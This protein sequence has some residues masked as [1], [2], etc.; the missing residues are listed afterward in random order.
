MAKRLTATI[1]KETKQLLINDFGYEPVDL[2]SY[3]GQIRALKESF[4]TLQIKNPKDPRL[5]QL[6]IAVK[7]LRADRE[8]EKD[9]TG[10]L[11]KTRKRRKDAKSLEQ[12]Q[13]EIDAKEKKP[14]AKTTK[15]TA[16]NIVPNQSKMSGAAKGIGKSPVAE[17]SQNILETIS[18]NVSK[19]V[20]TLKAM[21][22]LSVDE[23]K[24]DKLR[25]ED[26][27]REKKETSLEKSKFAVFKEVGS[28]ILKPFQG[29]FGK[30]LDFIKT[31]LLGKVLME[32][33]KWMGDKKNQKSLQNIFKFLKTFWPTLLAAYLLFGNSF[34]KMVVKITAKVAKFGV[35]IVKKLIPKLLAA[36]AKLKT[37]KFLNLIKGNKG[38]LITGLIATGV[39][40]YGISKMGGDDDEEEGG[41]EDTQEFK[42]GGFVSGPAGPDQVPARLTAGEFVMSKGAVEKYGVN[43]LAAMNAAG[44]GTNIPT[45]T[46]EY[47]DGGIV[48]RSRF[49]N[50]MGSP[51]V[52]ANNTQKVNYI[53]GGYVG[54]SFKFNAGKNIQGN[55]INNFNPVQKFISGGLVNNINTNN[56]VQ[57]FQGGG[58]VKASRKIDG[59]AL[60][61]TMQVADTKPTT[62]V[63]PPPSTNNN[64]VQNYNIQK[65]QQKKQYSGGGGTKVPQINAEKYVSKQ[66]IR[67]LGIMG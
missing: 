19:I 62:Q 56:V 61:N 54:E 42:Q 5:I 27:S 12:I 4:N 8:I 51:M 43:T 24:E 1:D 21:R 6:Q 9:T 16:A 2:E 35:M 36:L 30:I 58:T 40:A 38:K 63:V 65:E 10:T 67:T 7:D 66:K 49:Y 48:D 32:I 59:G 34:G 25:L 57:G 11:K 37:G 44:G 15:I 52:R 17:G 20:E 22:D 14:R 33:V 28:K 29:I 47:N 23:A 18:E 46:N 53:N 60:A 3:T 50:K 41:D 31:V 64:V 13:A 55:T 45:I 39:T 26:E